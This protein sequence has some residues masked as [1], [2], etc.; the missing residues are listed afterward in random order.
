M[1]TTPNTITVA[2]AGVRPLIASAIRSRS[3]VPVPP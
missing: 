3:S 2:L 1:N